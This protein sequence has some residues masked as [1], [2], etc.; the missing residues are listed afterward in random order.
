MI[1]AVEKQFVR[2]GRHREWMYQD[3][4]IALMPREYSARLAIIDHAASLIFDIV[5]IKSGRVAGEIALRIGD[6]PSLFYLGHVGYHVDPPYQGR[7]YAYRA[8]RLVMPVFKAFGYS[9]FV[10]TTDEDNHPSIR[11]CERL[12]CVLESTVDVPLW[13]SAEFQISRRK[14]R[15]ICKVI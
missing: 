5:D 2:C 10:I 15:Y 7:H 12:G 9:T 4:Q 13:C 8:C 3:E 6:G 1:R 11:T 14:R